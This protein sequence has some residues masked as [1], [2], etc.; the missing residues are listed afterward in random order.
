MRGPLVYNQAETTLWCALIHAPLAQMAGGTWFRPTAVWVRI[1][2][3]ALRLEAT[4]PL[5]THKGG[6]RRQLRR[7]ITPASTC[8]SI[9]IRQ[10]NC[11]QNAV[12]VG[13]TPTRSTMPPP[14]DRASGYEPLRLG[15]NP[16]GV[17]MD[18]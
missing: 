8:F 9:P 13:S 16:D 15:S 12:S 4:Y 18:V 14:E 6:S 10:R 3:G 1:P 2:G 11:I 7:N 5:S 17:T